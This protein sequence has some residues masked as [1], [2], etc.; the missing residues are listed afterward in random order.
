MRWALALTA[1]GALALVL[2]FA[3]RLLGPSAPDIASSASRP[4]GGVTT[5]TRPGAVLELLPEDRVM[6]EV[7]P[8]RRTV[9]IS[10]SVRAVRTAFVKARI[11]GELT[12]VRVREGETVKAGQVVAEQDASELD[13][14]LRQAEQQV[15]SA[16]AQ[17][18]IAQRALLNNRA[19]VA[20]GFISPTVLEAS[21]S[22]E[23]AAQ[24]SLQGSIAAADIARKSRADAVL[25]A[26]IG[27]TVSQRLAQAGERV[28]VDARILEIV[29]LSELELE[30]TVAPD[31]AV[32]LRPGQ[33]ALVQIEGIPTALPA[34]LARINPTAQSGSRAV[35]AY[36]SLAPHPAL[37]QGSFA[38]GSI[39]VEERRLLSLPA[40]A[41]RLEGSRPYVLL[42]QGDSVVRR[43]VSLGARG[44]SHAGERI[45]I[46]SGLEIG[47]YVLAG[48]VAAVADGSRWRI[49]AASSPA[50]SAVPAVSGSAASAAPPTRAASR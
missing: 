20:Q 9:S 18:E 30:A 19:L 15:V 32:L 7:T 8:L 38:S 3:P 45:Q 2:V 23:A 43:A 37:R 16:R 12:A 26:P 21:T 14:R 5:A 41:V 44:Q 42:L 27:G 33:S 13:L 35:L 24:A 50:A 47:A 29:D 48:S 39:T 46:E 36:L 40:S 6:A 10:G 34:R 11:A 1:L 25:S 28:G 4:P 17:L 49:S 22:N 31:E